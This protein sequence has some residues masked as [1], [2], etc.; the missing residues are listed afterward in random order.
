MKKSSCVALVLSILLT[1]SIFGQVK[2]FDLKSTRSTV[3][4]SAPKP[5]TNVSKPKPVPASPIAFT[6]VKKVDVNVTQIEYFECPKCK[7]ENAKAGKCLL[8]G[9]AL[10]RKTKSFTY[11]CKLCGYISEK[12]G[13]CPNCKGN[14]DLKK[15]E[16]TYQDVGCKVV[17]SEP[18]KCP[19]CKQDLKRII[20][21]EL[22]K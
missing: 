5:I 15:F 16:V 11:K 21:V 13:K 1:G 10:V 9:I 8:H 19:K 7:R 12:E 18:G 6:V 14:P 17:S 22:K 20:N 4:T 2:K 3:A